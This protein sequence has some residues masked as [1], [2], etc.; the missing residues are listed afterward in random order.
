MR[1][2]GESELVAGTDEVGRGPIAGS[3]FAA[4]VIFPVG[5][6]FPTGLTDSKKLTPAKRESLFDQLTSLAL[7]WA[8]AEAS[9]EEIDRY[10]ILQA[11]LLA[12]KRA[13][14][15]LDPAPDR[16]M[17]DGNRLPVWHFKAT[18]VVQGDLLVPI[19]SAASVIAKVSRDRYMKQ[20][21][22]QFPGYEFDRHAGYPTATHLLRLRELGPCSIHRRS[23]RPV[24][25]IL[26]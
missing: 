11:S 8:V 5:M 10:N 26:S 19:I 23:F 6:N 18:A 9:V 25:E 14:T 12:M 15:A 16:V 4:A 13:V 22:Q 1:A 17:V 3:V 21:N 20:M 2:L 24:R 7:C